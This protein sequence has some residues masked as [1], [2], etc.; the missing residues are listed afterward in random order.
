MHSKNLYL[1]RTKA[2]IYYYQRCIPARF[3]ENNKYPSSVFK[4]SL[5]TT[6]KRTA[7]KIS[8]RIS[9]KIDQIA[10]EHFDNPESFATAMKLLYQV[11][12]EQIS[13]AQYEELDLSEY[14]DHLLTKAEQFNKRVNDYISKLEDENNRLI[15]FITENKSSTNI[16]KEEISQLI[17]DS[18]EKP[19]PDEQNPKLRYLLEQFLQSK[20]DIREDVYKPDIELFIRYLDDVYSHETKIAEVTRENIR[21]YKKFYENTPKGL[22]TSLLSITEIAKKTGEKKKPKT[23]IDHFGKLRTFL[24]FI[25]SETYH[26][27]SSLSIILANTQDLKKQISPDPARTI[28]SDIDLKNIFNSPEYTETCDFYTSAMYFVPLIA[29]FTGARMSE[30]L[31]LEKKD[32]QKIEN[33]YV[34][35]FNED[36]ENSAD[37]QKRLK[38]KSARRK[39]P[40][41]DQLLQ[42]DFITYVESVKDRL[43]PDELRNNKGKFHNFQ[44]RCNYYIRKCNVK[45]PSKDVYKD[46][47]SFRHTVETILNE[48]SNTGTPSQ[49]FDSVLIDSIIGHSNQ[50]KSIGQKIYNHADQLRAKHRAINR[51]EYP[52]IDFRKIVSWQKCTFARKPF[53]AALTNLK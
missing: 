4:L 31:Q 3:L 35:D 8:H 13:L 40:I 10:R 2:G 20:S 25:E 16:S 26:I 51:I 9:V 48:L 24:V 39:V 29:L 47:H 12:S 42:L 27:D 49:R 36:S 22:R 43:F 1:T 44:R 6:S 52:A 33:I 50:T 46:F 53:R 38:S 18:F 7:L 14:E 28:L 45:R 11:V 5:R 30:I 32:I 19:I 23:I 15:N 34:I 21:S 37:E 41:H 17:A